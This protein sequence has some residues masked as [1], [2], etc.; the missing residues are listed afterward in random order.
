MTVQNEERLGT[1]NIWKLML[2]MGIPTFIAQLINL[3][4]NIVDR[5]YIGHIPASGPAALTGIGLC[6]PIVSVISAFSAFVGAGGAPLAA[7]AMGKGDKERAQSILSNGVTMLLSFSVILTVLFYLTKRPLLY[8]FGASD[9]TFPYAD[10]YLS[11]YLSGTVFVQL[12]IGLN[13]FITA[14]GRP[15]IAMMSVLIGA[16][17]NIILDPV[18]IFV[19]DMGTRGA[20]VATIISQAV[21]AVWVIWF[22]TSRQA[23]LSVSGKNMYPQWKIIGSVAALGISPFIMQSTESLIS[24]VLNSGLQ[25]YGGDLYV[26]SL[27][28]MQSV[29][30]LISV[31]I[32]G[33]SQGVQPIISYNYGAGNRGRVKKTCFS[34][35]ALTA[36]ISFFLTLTAVLFPEMFSGIFTDDAE[37]IALCGRTMPVFLA[38]ML[39]FGI[40]MGCQQSFMALGQ[41]RFSLFFALLRKV[42]LLIPLAIILPAITG[43][44]MGVYVAEPVSDSIAA[45]TCGTVFALNFKKILN[46]N[47]VM[48]AP[49]G[50]RA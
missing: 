25:H 7:I 11:V 24:I 12:T 35:I 41:A 40:Q 49:E 14:Q 30:Q 34:V 48:Q 9:V 47:E 50:R 26:G 27:T 6:F 32:Q 29:M 13:P 36:G 5:I 2:T 45:A 16:L 22:L 4:Y 46:K 15:R 20:A 37:L 28:I 3:L 42:I 39:I 18:F 17:L 44:V 33:F 8:M 31:P 1:E 19:L 21:S 23:S 43:S 38:G 10:A